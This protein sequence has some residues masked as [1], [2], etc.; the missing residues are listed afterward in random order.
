MKPKT[1]AAQRRAADEWDAKHKENRQYRVAKSTT[2]RFI[3]TLATAED[4][5]QVK[6]WLD[7]RTSDDGEQSQ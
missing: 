3:T 2:K 5:A 6:A 1:S 4:L 7:E